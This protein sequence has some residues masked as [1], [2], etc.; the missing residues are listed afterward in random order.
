MKD[1]TTLTF[2]GTGTSQ[3]IPVIGSDHPVCLSADIKDKRLRSSVLI[4]GKPE[5]IIKNDDVRRVYLG[6][7]F[8][9]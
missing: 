5:D 9:I 3:G 6:E 7:R 2:L 4:E 8:S 1:S